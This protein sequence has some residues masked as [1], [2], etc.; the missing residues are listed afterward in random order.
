MRRSDEKVLD[1]ILVAGL[2][3][4]ASLAAANLL[5]VNAERGALE[6]ARMRDGDDHILDG[7]QVLELDFR[8]LLDDLRSPQV[9]V[10]LLDFP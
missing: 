10:V 4:Q 2:H 9:S 6:V 1:E 7:D 8:L 3:P 5:A